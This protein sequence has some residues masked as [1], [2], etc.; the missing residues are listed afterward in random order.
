M[1]PN[2]PPEGDSA[3]R[4]P[5]GPPSDVLYSQ[6]RTMRQA[7]EDGSEHS[8]GAISGAW[9]VETFVVALALLL[10]GEMLGI[11]AG[12]YTFAAALVLAAAVVFFVKRRRP[13]NSAK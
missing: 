10:F 3:R 5:G 2:I 4:R 7:P 6:C 8:H 12:F 13:F 9:L 1:L 11:A